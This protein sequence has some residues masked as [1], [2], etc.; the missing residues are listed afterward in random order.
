MNW[1]RSTENAVVI[2]I[3]LEL[4]KVCLATAGK[5]WSNAYLNEMV[6]REKIMQLET[7]S[8]GSEI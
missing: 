2:L 7:Y 3:A 1:N 5:A 4:F 6:L 8:S